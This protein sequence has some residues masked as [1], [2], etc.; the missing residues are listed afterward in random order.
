MEGLDWSP[1]LRAMGLFGLAEGITTSCTSAVCL[2]IALNEAFSIL[3]CVLL[4]L[5]AIVFAVLAWK[6]SEDPLMRIYSIVGAVLMPIAGVCCIIVDEDFVKTQH[7]ASKAPAF[8]FIAAAVV[9][10][11][12]INIIQVVKCLTC[13]QIKDRLLTTPMQVNIFLVLNLIAGLILGLVFGFIDPEDEGSHRSKMTITTVVFLF[14]GIIIGAGFGF[15]N[16]DQTQQIQ[17]PATIQERLKSTEYDA[18]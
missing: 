8:M 16:E 18:M 11:F 7:P 17:L 15:Y 3:F 12:V 14:V 5:F 4:C 2:G 10:N 1:A 9:I 6:S 13:Y